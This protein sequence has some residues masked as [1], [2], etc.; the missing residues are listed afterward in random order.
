MNKG[1]GY[2]LNEDGT[3][4]KIVE[5]DFDEPIE[6]IV[7]EPVPKGMAFPKWDGEKWSGLLEETQEEITEEPKK[8][9][10][11]P[12][13]ANVLKNARK[14]AMKQIDAMAGHLIEEILSKHKQMNLI[15]SN[16]AHPGFYSIDIIRQNANRLEVFINKS[17]SLK[18]IRGLDL[19]DEL[20]K[21]LE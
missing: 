15:R 5:V 8:K 20:K 9:T 12:K 19:L 14:L 13:R 16:Q 2:L 21:G 10:G 7:T 6:G 18:E 17:R 1:F 4:N 11:K 3:I